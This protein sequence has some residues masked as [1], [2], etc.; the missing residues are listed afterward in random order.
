LAGNGSFLSLSAFGLYFF[1]FADNLIKIFLNSLCRTASLPPLPSLRKWNYP[2]TAH[3]DT[4]TVLPQ[5]P[6]NTVQI[7][8]SMVN[9]EFEGGPN[10]GTPM[11]DETREYLE[12]VLLE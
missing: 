9:I 12:K 7:A 3:L 4:G 6:G 2:L 5:D 10:A 1:H 8:N 11:D